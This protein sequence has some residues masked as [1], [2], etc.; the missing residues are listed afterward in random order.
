MVDEIADPNVAVLAMAFK[1]S[2]ARVRLFL[3]GHKS[4]LYS[5]VD[6]SA[7]KAAK[8]KLAPFGYLTR[9]FV[10]HFCLERFVTYA[11]NGRVLDPGERMG[12]HARG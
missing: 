5:V 8:A 10:G 6:L 1:S 7:Q 12:C 9:G 11:D 2:V 4:K 3:A